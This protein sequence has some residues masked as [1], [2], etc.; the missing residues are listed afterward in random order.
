MKQPWAFIAM[1]GASVYF[2][3]T[4]RWYRMGGSL[5]REALDVDQQRNLIRLSIGATPT[6]AHWGSKMTPVY[7][8]EQLNIRRP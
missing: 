3:L 1:N 7:A 8:D 4:G 6:P 5:R 2:E